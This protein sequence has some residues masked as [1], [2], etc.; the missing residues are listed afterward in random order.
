[1]ENPEKHLQHAS[2]VMKIVGWGCLLGLPLS[3][4]IYP[5]GILWGQVSPD[6]CIPMIGPD[7]PP[8]PFDGFH[9]Y[10]F[11]LA[12]MYISLGFLLVRGASQP[13]RNIAL[14]DYG[15][16]SSILHGG[17]MIP[18]AFYYPNEHAHMWAD[19]PFAALVVVLLI[20]WHPKKADAQAAV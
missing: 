17:I 15:I 16:Y 6:F 2:L 10:F 9:P 14:F 5:P 13:L 1:M 18:M 3:A 20:T 7:H 4:L 12:S 11:M 8:S 19:I